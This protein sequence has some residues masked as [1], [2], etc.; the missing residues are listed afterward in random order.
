[1]SREH[2]ADALAELQG[3][4]AIARLAGQQMQ[5]PQTAREEAAHWK[6]AQLSQT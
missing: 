2:R 4:I 6:S 1:M 5:Q 3:G